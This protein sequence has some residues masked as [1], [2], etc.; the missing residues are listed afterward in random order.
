ME[1]LKALYSK[2]S[3]E[4]GKNLKASLRKL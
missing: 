3:T 4:D 1:S 2:L